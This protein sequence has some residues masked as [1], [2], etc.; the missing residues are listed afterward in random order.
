MI[1]AQLSN[2]MRHVVI[3]PC[4]NKGLQCPCYNMILKIMNDDKKTVID[5]PTYLEYRWCY[6]KQD[7]YD[8]DNKSNTT[9]SV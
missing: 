8:R 9:T 2:T 7:W 1:F 4:A 3:E 5:R 6:N